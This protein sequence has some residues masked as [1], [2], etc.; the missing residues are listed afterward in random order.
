MKFDFME[1]E[2]EMRA[3]I[4]SVGVVVFSVLAI[5]A[6]VLSATELFYLLAVLAIALGIYMAYHVSKAPARTQQETKGQRKRARKQ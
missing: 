2:H 4:F 6:L 3:F 5:I 1:D